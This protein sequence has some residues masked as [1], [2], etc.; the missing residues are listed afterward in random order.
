MHA[1][2]TW[3]F[4]A[5]SILTRREFTAGAEHGPESWPLRGDLGRADVVQG[6]AGSHPYADRA[7]GQ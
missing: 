4:D 3:N 7:A 5:T 2:P 1:M 6:D